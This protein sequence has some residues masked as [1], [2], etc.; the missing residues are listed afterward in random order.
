MQSFVKMIIGILVLM[1]STAT[2]AD[3]DYKFYIKL[4]GVYSPVKS[5]FSLSCGAKYYDIKGKIWR[6]AKKGECKA[7]GVP[8]ICGYPEFKIPY[9]VRNMGIKSGASFLMYEDAPGQLP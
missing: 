3:G 7:P 5:P 4:N 8:S 9:E 1:F 6:C 2:I